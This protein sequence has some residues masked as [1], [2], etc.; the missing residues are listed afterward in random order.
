MALLVVVL[1]SAARIVRWL[2]DQP[3]WLDE[4]MIA[5][6]IRDRGFA[7]LATDLA[8]DQSAPIG[9]LWSQRL[10]HL[11]LGDSGLA[12]RLVPLLFGVGTLVLAY[13]AGRRLLGP[14]GTL[15]LVTLLAVNGSLMRYSTE[16]KQYS[17]DAFTVLL[18]LAL[19]V[20]AFRRPAL[21]SW[22][23]SFWGAAAVSGL[24]STAA[25]MATPGIALVVLVVAVR[26]TGWIATVRRH[27]AGIAL[28]TVSV[29]AHYVLALRYAIGDD[30]LAALNA[31]LGFPPEG[32]VPTAR[33]LLARPVTLAGDPIGVPW[34]LAVVFWLLA[35]AG[36][37]AAALLPH[38][39]AV[40][41]TAG[42]G[43]G[44]ATGESGPSVGMPGAAAGASD[45]AAGVSGPGAGVS[46]AAAGASG[47]GAGV[48]G[49]AA[50]GS[51]EAA[52]VSGP[53]AGAS[54]EAAGASGAGAGVSGVAAG[55][56]DEAAGVSGA[57][58]GVS[59]SGA[60]LS[61]SGDG[62]SGSD[63]RVEGW[64][65]GS[66][67]VLGLVLAAPVVSAFGAAAVHAVPLYGRF[68]VQLLPP[69]FLAVAI[70]ADVIAAWLLGAVASRVTPRRSAV[71]ARGLVATA[72][73]VVL[74]ALA[75]FAVAPAAVAAARPAPLTNGV[76][77]RAAVAALVAAH[78]PGDLVV[79]TPSSWPA[80]EW[81]AGA[82]TLDPVLL[83]H[84]TCMRSG[85]VLEQVA[86]DYSRVLVYL[87]M[88]AG[89]TPGEAKVA[90]MLARHGT[91]T[92][93]EKFG[94]GALYTL[95]LGPAGPSP[96]GAVPLA[97][98]DCL[99]VIATNG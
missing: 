95:T 3:L 55:A 2:A 27:L 15:V 42:V 26:E 64:R 72:G 65:R 97:K 37:I 21:G 10:V 46:G 99:K 45:E 12:L 80:V 82:T 51:D 98:N 8:H 79:V 49:A 78:R 68:A 20:F 63:G 91:V 11:T 74:A 81:Y 62:V 18:L 35:L 16:L 86:P 56:S 77:D 67:W 53:A 71:A 44:S 75:V 28:W 60:E 24:F 52:G 19:A 87:G 83:L 39:S 54:D 17:A 6:N 88:Q 1:G 69:L 41:Q 85:P 96:A 76:D 57:A 43:A 7:G 23:L 70:A 30:T 47:A 40:E 33:W 32:L 29:G 58:A 59:G 38:R 84:T 50:G 22:A 14:A 61:G 89:G 4:Q 93:P 48:S 9:W 73:A 5:I 94:A 25:I 34:W 92:G 90:T 66:R 36:A 31:R 13:W